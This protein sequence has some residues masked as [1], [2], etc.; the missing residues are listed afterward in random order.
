MAEQKSGERAEEILIAWQNA[1][2]QRRAEFYI[3]N[4]SFHCGKILR[5]EI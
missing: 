5:S 3:S 4:S 1:Y 2:S